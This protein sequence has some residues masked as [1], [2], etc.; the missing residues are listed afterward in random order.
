MRVIAGLFSTLMP[1]FGQIYNRQ[2]VKGIIFVIC[3]H[4]DNVA[5]N[6]NSAIHLDFN[7]H[8]AQAVGA[9]D[10]GYMLFYPGFYAYAI[11]DA[12]YY[13]KPGADKAKTAIPYLI[14]GFA[15]EFCAIFA[16][17]L[18]FPTLM[19]GLSMLVPIYAGM[20]IHRKEG[21]SVPEPSLQAPSDP[22]E[23]RQ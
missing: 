17:R 5:G 2:F 16:N 3:E 20:L 14:G 6:I 23:T 15:G 19:A 9:T 4:F 21:Q 10:F 11:W 7:G 18:P 12:W 22:P 1:G 13:A 8:H